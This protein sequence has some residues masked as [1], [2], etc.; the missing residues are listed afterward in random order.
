[1]HG[2]GGHAAYPHTVRDPVLAAAAVVLAV[3]QLPSR[4]VDPVRGAVCTVGIVRGGTMANVVPDSVTLAGTLR[5]ADPSDRTALLSALHEVVTATATAYGCRAE[6][7]EVSAEPA[8]VN[9]PA[10]ADAAAGVLT[11]LGVM[12]E[13]TWRSFG[14]DDFSYYGNVLPALMAFVGVDGGGGLHEARFLP[15]DGTVE[16]VARAL[17]GCY[18]A[19]ATGTGTGPGG[20][21][22]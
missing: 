8:L 18:L 1:M 22:R 15:P 5:A 17:V 2:R 20:V 6:V 10:L 3:Q 4:R 21:S 16:L 7:V 19:A 12:V 11:E 14:S 9:H 13:R